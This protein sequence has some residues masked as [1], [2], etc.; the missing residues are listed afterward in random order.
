MQAACAR[1]T[2]CIK[3]QPSRKITYFFAMAT[4]TQIVIEQAIRQLRTLSAILVAEIQKPYPMDAQLPIEKRICKE[5]LMTV[6]V[7][8]PKL[9]QAR[10]VVDDA[11]PTPVQRCTTCED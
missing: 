6:G 11:D 10:L 4:R 1:V 9:Q 3:I 7:L 2:Y 8:L 5:A